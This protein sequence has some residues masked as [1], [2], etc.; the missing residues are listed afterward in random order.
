MGVRKLGYL[1]PST[2]EVSDAY[3]DCG[4]TGVTGTPHY[5]ANTR[6]VQFANQAEDRNPLEQ[7][8]L[9][10][11]K[12][13]VPNHFDDVDFPE[14]EAPVKSAYTYSNSVCK[15]PQKVSQVKVQDFLSACEV[16]VD[17]QKKRRCQKPDFLRVEPPECEPGDDCVPCQVQQLKRDL[18]RRHSTGR[19]PDCK[20]CYRYRIH[21]ADMKE[22][23]DTQSKVI[24]VCK[25]AVLKDKLGVK[26]PPPPPASVMAILASPGA[27]PSPISHGT[28]DSEYDTEKRDQL[29]KKFI[30]KPKVIHYE[31][32]PRDRVFF[33]TEETAS[34]G[35]V[36]QPYLFQKRQVVLTNG[37]KKS[38]KATNPTYTVSQL[39]LVF[40]LPDHNPALPERHPSPPMRNWNKNT[41]LPPISVHKVQ[42]DDMNIN[43]PDVDTAG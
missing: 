28:P 36:H 33:Y 42:R 15:H 35:I 17:R 31:C 34:Q 3:Q 18:R 26:T 2:A 43:H 30:P 29:I 24:P 19:W 6:R 32:Q 13:N 8:F 41:V 40:T 7:E 14:S 4:L 39:G 27:T 16:E 37:K 22:S 10:R 23:A 5:N 38:K 12:E 1:P 21:R 20:L 11:V 25:Q 9:E